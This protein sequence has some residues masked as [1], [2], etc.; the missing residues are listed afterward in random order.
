MSDRA[1]PS[2]GKAQRCYQRV[3]VH[4]TTMR[5]ECDAPKPP[6]ARSLDEVL[7]QTD[8]RRSS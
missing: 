5:A 3:W 6:S 4:L 7:R 8:P 1:C 2:C